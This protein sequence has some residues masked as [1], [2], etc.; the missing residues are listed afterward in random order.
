L[1]IKRGVCRALCSQAH[2]RVPVAIAAEFV[3]RTF[4]THNPMHQLD[5]FAVPFGSGGGLDEAF[6]GGGSAARSD[7]GDLNWISCGGNPTF[8]A[9]PTS[10]KWFAG[11]PS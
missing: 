10:P 2:F 3:F 8:A 5:S 4:R 7:R 9:S 11:D 1:N 6:E